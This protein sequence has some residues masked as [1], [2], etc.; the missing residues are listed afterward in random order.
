MG[1]LHKESGGVDDRSERDGDDDVR[2]LKIYQQQVQCIL[3]CHC[4]FSKHANLRFRDDVS[5]RVGGR[6]RGWAASKAAE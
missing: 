1:Q 3:S 5:L 4:V 6:R 2:L